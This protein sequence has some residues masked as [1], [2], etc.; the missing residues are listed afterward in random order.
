M[1]YQFTC[2]IEISWTFTANMRLHTFMSKYVLGWCSVI[3]IVDTL[4]YPHCQF[5]S[6][7]QMNC[8]HIHTIKNNSTQVNNHMQSVDVLHWLQNHWWT[9]LEAKQN[10]KIIIMTNNVHRMQYHSLIIDS[11]DIVSDHWYTEA[12]GC[13][14]G[15]GGMYECAIKAESRTCNILI[16]GFTW[17]AEILRV[18]CNIKDNS[19]I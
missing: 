8:L 19:K 15:E 16:A 12:P 1:M 18:W 7:P 11:F 10:I 14:H 3:F 6:L 17:W 4:W 13:G 2:C 5:Q 9:V